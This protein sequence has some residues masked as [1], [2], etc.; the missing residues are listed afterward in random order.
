MASLH[1]RPKIR[2]SGLARYLV[3]NHRACPTS[4]ATFEE[5]SLTAYLRPLSQG[6]RLRIMRVL[7]EWERVGDEGVRKND[8]IA[9]REEKVNRTT[10]TNV[11]MFIVMYLSKGY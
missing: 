4:N 11:L 3:A 9:L 8:V 1:A 2:Y 10:K 6:G 7:F 5:T